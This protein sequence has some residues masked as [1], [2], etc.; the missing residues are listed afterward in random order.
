MADSRSWPNGFFDDDAIQLPVVFLREAGFA[1][2][3]HDKREKF[4]E[5]RRG[6]GRGCLACCDFFGSGD[7]FLE[8]LVGGGITKVA[9]YVVDA[10]DGTTPTELRREERRKVL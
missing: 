8:A 9:L 1:E 4:R 2:L 6:N 3:A 10:F 7:L 5:R